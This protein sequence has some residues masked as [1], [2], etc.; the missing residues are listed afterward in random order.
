[1]L[2]MEISTAGKVTS[3]SPVN[4]DLAMVIY[5]FEITNL[6]FASAKELNCWLYKKV[7]MVQNA[8]AHVLIKSG[9]QELITQGPHSLYWPAIK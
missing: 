8:T 4:F 2:G 5:V 6:A 3:P 1:M 9:P 7:Q